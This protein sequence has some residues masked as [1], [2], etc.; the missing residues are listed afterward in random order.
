MRF[1]LFY[2]DN[3]VPTMD[4]AHRDT[5]IIYPFGHRTLYSILVHTHAYETYPHVYTLSLG[6]G[7]GILIGFKC[8]V[9]R[10]IRDML[11]PSVMSF[12]THLG[13]REVMAEEAA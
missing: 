1:A 3:A 10:F 5:P 4:M 6:K 12:Y 13:S 7:F 9:W 2:G 11:S 8:I